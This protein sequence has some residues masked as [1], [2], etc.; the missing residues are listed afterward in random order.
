MVS[1]SFAFVR[2]V[3]SRLSVV[4]GI[5]TSMPDVPPAFVV[6]FVQLGRTACPFSV[7]NIQ[8]TGL[9]YPFMIGLI[10]CSKTLRTAKGYNRIA[11]TAGG[12]R[13]GFLAGVE[14]G[15]RLHC[16]PGSR[17]GIPSKFKRR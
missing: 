16:Q 10:Q 2:F 6:T 7:A 13:R 1:A 8:E 3:I 14:I 9:S 11:V 17:F 5:L 4:F 15:R 12:L